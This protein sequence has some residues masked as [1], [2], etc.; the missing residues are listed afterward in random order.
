MVVGNS[1]AVSGGVAESGEERRMEG[2]MGGAWGAFVR[3]PRSGLEGWGWG[4]YEVGGRGLVRLGEGGR[5]GVGFGRGD[6]FD[7]EC[8]DVRLEG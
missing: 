8:G 3:D 7:G 2:V 5:G 4:R 1:V 6:G